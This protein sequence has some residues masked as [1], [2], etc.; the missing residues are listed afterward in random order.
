MY[1]KVLIQFDKLS[2]SYITTS[3]YIRAQDSQII[4]IIIKKTIHIFRGILFT[5]APALHIASD[6]AKIT[7]LPN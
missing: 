5:A 4:G 1:Y 2:K 3:T 6:I 7:L